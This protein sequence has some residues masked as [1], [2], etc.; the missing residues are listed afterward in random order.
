LGCFRTL[1]FRAEPDGKRNAVIGDAWVLAVE[2]ESP[3]RAYSILA[4]G[5]SARPESPHHDD[6]AEAFAR[7]RL[8]RVAFTERDIEASVIRRYRPGRDRP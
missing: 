4:Y 5:Q 3:P 1:T 2:F 8:K 7:G 6:Q